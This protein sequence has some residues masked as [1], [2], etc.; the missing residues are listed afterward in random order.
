MTA[1]WKVGLWTVSARHCFTSARASKAADRTGLGRLV[2]ATAGAGRTT[3]RAGA[4]G[5]VEAG[6][7]PRRTRAV[8]VLRRP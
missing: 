7:D 6:F 3:G 2:W 1:V 8:V 4:A 5:T